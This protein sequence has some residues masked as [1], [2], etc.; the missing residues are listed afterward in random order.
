MLL[1][2]SSI[3]RKAYEKENYFFWLYAPPLIF[4]IAYALSDEKILLR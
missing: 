2:N 1:C 4:F 3:W